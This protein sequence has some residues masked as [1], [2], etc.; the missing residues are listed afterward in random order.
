[1]NSTRITYISIIVVLGVLTASI[2]AWNNGWDFG[3]QFG[4]QQAIIDGKMEIDCKFQTNCQKDYD[5]GYLEGIIQSDPSS[6][7]VSK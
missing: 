6:C 7:G 4:Y 3:N 2:S 1:M 5:R